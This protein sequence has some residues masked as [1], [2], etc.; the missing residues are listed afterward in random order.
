MMT[1]PV[2]YT[3]LKRDVVRLKARQRGNALISW[4]LAAALGAGAFTGL[5]VIYESNENKTALA[6][7]QN[8]M[9]EM[10]SNARSTYGTDDLYGQVTTATA[11]SGGVVPQALRVIGTGTARNPFNGAITF[12][13]ATI[14]TTND[15]LSI[16]WGSHPSRI[17]QQL[18]TLLNKSA[19]Q[20]Q[21]GGS[22]VKPPDG[23]LN[24]ATLATQCDSSAKVDIIFTIGRG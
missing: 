9:I 24:V 18:V 6:F 8:V 5:Y 7:S 17:C 15:S 23:T 20:I 16:G 14:T 21:V 19:R 13:P 11:V 4:M 3:V 12:T 1:K 2:F 10:I 22:D